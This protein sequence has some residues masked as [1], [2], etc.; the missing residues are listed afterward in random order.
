MEDALRRPVGGSHPAEV[1]GILSS[2]RA[3]RMRARLDAKRERDV[4]GKGDLRERFE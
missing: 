4:E 2:K 1:A 3:D